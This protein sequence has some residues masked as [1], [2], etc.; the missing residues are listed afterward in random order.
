MP[1]EQSSVPV[2]EFS[3]FVLPTPIVMFV[4]CAGEPRLSVPL[5]GSVTIPVA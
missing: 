3:V 1:A 4:R 5:A 2:Y